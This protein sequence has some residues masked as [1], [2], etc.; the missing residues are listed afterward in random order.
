M[1][2]AGAIA[3]DRA[4]IAAGIHSGGL[5]RE[6]GDAIPLASERGYHVVVAGPVASP[7][8]PSMPS[9]G[10]MGNTVT[11]AGLRAAGQV[12][13]ASLSAPPDWRRADIL[14]HPVDRPPIPRSAGTC[15]RAV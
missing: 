6:V 11:V 15:R 4:V 2:D 10:R 1:T 14:L 5:A 7:R 8:R 12:E 3:C 9:D 13:L